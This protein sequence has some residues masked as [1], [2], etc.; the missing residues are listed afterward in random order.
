M[1]FGT[2]TLLDVEKLHK[3]LDEMHRT[4][5]DIIHSVNYQMTYSKS[6]DFAV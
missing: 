4:E 5:G 2:A 3:T 6:L 1:G